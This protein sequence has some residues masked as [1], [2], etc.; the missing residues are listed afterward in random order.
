MDTKQLRELITRQPFR[1]IQIATA[2]GDHYTILE[3]AD[4]FNNRRRP[5][6]YVIFTEDGLAH[7]IESG[8]I[9]SVTSLWRRAMA[10]P[11]RIGRPLEGIK[12][13]RPAIAAIGRITGP[14]N[15]A[16]IFRFN[17][18]DVL[19]IENECSGEHPRG[20]NLKRSIGP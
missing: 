16:A 2:A 13:H 10:Y 3:E 6:L 12:N 8:D 1:P 15:F 4:V 7:W 14:Q 18:I 19:R 17:I 9:V 11:G 20:E 5:E